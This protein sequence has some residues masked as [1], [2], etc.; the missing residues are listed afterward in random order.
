M[1]RAV[2]GIT[3]G[4]S[5]PP[6][7]VAPRPIDPRTIP[8][9][10]PLTRHRRWVAWGYTWTP[11]GEHGGKWDKPPRQKTFA[12][13]H[14]DNPKT[15]CALDEIWPIVEGD[16]RFDGIGLELLGLKLAVLDL[17]DV[18]DRSTGALASWAWELVRLAWDAGAYV[19]ITPSQ[20][21]VRII[22]TSHGS[23]TIHTKKS[24]PSGVGSFEIYMNLTAGHA[25]YIT[26]TGHQI[27]KGGG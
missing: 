25:R 19:E 24:H 17:D 8:A 12:L 11:K 16:K 10:V 2:T 22:G 23:A 1:P 26:V 9:L 5:A 15:W 13:A 7:P 14:N 20:C 4:D 6:R 27:S 18:R 21:G 3:G